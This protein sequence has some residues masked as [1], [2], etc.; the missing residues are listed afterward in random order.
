MDAYTQVPHRVFIE[1]PEE[2]S[3]TAS[4]IDVQND[5]DVARSERNVLQ[6]MAYLPSAATSASGSF[7]RARYLLL[8]SDL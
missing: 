6:W 1:L 5:A 7:A 8:S 2:L 3:D 4:S